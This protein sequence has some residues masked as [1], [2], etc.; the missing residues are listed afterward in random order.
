M[1]TKKK[2][3]IKIVFKFTT[4]QFENNVYIHYLF[5]LSQTRL[6]FKLKIISSRSTCLLNGTAKFKSILSQTRTDL[7]TAN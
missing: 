4:H 6:F 1:L 2:K 5:I 3:K 7:Q